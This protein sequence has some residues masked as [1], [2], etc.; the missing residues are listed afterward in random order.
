MAA[1]KTASTKQSKGKAL[2]GGA[3]VIRSAV[4]GIGGK[5]SM[6]C[7]HLKFMMETPGI[8]PVA[9]CEPVVA[10][11]SIACEVCPGVTTYASLDDMLKNADVDQVTIVVPH[12][13]HAELALKCLKAGKH[14]IVEKPMCI[15][16]REATAMIEAAKKAGV[17]LTVFHQ[18]RHHDG[19]YQAMKKAID[20]GLIGKVFHIEAF[21]GGWGHD[22]T[23]RG[24]KATSGGAFYDWGAH[25]MDWLL[26]LA[27]GK[28]VSVDGY[29]HKLKWPQFTNEDHVEANIRFDSGVVANIQMSHMAKA[30]KPRWQILGTEGALVDRDDGTLKVY[31]DVDGYPGEI[32]IRY[33][34]TFEWRRYYDNIV[35][36]L[37]K[38]AE[39][40][41]K[42]EE[43]R[44]VVAVF[45]TAEKSSK[46][47]KTM[48]L[49]YE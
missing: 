30:G 19:D 43:G 8:E 44:R 23:W 48:P 20:D 21:C 13:L 6:G 10:R 11:H 16:V 31:K 26:N 32:T 3:K 25:F 28:V 27:P 34:R 46:A 36:H 49:P 14:V 1:R 38:G 42:P 15:S 40:N 41:I 33:N 39:L 4:V 35:D 18:R 24:M 5:N 37:L 47:G 12:N 29:F 17:M 9:V 2:M 45:E 22:S 7:G